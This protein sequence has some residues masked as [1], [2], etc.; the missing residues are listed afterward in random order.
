[1]KHFKATPRAVLLSGKIKFITQFFG[2]I[3]PVSRMAQIIG[4]SPKRCHYLL[5]HAEQI[6]PAFMLKLDGY[7]DVP[8]DTFW[9]LCEHEWEKGFARNKMTGPLNGRDWQMLKRRIKLR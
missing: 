7:Y 8:D 5:R 1:M 3:E 9:N 2:P 4:I 6:S